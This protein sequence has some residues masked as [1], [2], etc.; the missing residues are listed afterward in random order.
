MP[1]AASVSGT[2]SVDM[3]APKAS[4]KAV[5]S[6]TRMKISQTW[7]ASQTGVSERWIRARG[8]APFPA[9]PATRSQKPPPK[10]APPKIA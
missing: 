4:G 7:L 6:T 9:S 8:R 2:Y 3:I 1:K 5:Q 10:S